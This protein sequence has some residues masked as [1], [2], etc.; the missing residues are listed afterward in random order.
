MNA[1]R[2]KT[3][4]IAIAVKESPVSHLVLQYRPITSRVTMITTAKEQQTQ[5]L[6]RPS[7]ILA[8]VLN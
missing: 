1:T 8:H 2:M 6:T 5:T 4:A 3:Q 7:D